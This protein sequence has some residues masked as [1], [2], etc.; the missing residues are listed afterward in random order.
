MIRRG[1]VGGGGLYTGEEL[2]RVE[3]RCRAELVRLGSDLPYDE[4]FGRPAH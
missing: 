2:D 4:L 1:E 3:A